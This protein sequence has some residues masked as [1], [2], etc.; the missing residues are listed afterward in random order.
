[1]C[2]A[3]LRT[4]GFILVSICIWRRQQGVSADHLGK[5]CYLRLS[6]RRRRRLSVGCTRI[7]IWWSW[8]AWTWRCVEQISTPSAWKHGCSAVVA[9]VFSK[10]TGPWSSWSGYRWS[11]LALTYFVCIEAG[12]V[13]SSCAVLIQKSKPSATKSLPP[14]QRANRFSCRVWNGATWIALL[15]QITFTFVAGCYWGV[16][17]AKSWRNSS[18]STSSNMVLTTFLPTILRPFFFCINCRSRA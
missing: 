2:V 3:F 11:R 4:N 18:L 15:D 10:R 12:R 1:M 9:S 13:E 17:L 16:P 5:S 7:W 14:K 6:L 8:L